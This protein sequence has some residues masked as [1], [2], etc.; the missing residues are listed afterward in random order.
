MIFRGFRFGMLLQL[1]IGPMCLMVF[2]TA[3][4]DGFLMGMAIVAAIALVDAAY[5]AL[6]GVGVA[7]VLDKPRIRRAFK[8]FGSIILA[9]FGLNILLGAF[10]LSLLPGIS[11]LSGAKA[12]NLF[13]Q[14]LILTASSPLTIVFWGGVFTAEAASKQLG[15]AQLVF[16]SVGCVLSTLV[17]LT[18][19][20]LLGSILN[21]FVP[22][23]VITVLNVLVGAALILFGLRLL[24]K[25]EPAPAANSK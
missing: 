22:D 6:A 16:F 3:G 11:L 12:G 9:L 17:F 10:E 15:K 20:A 21:S 13:L 23:M 7:S 4:R 19:V 25:R 8:V 18:L 1:S 14:G 2:N 5:I 24:L